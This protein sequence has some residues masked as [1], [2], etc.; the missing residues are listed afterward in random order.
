MLR[1]RNCSRPGDRLRFS[2]SARAG[3]AAALRPVP[4]YTVTGVRPRASLARQQGSCRLPP[5][6]NP[7]P[8]PP[9]VAAPRFSHQDGPPETRNGP[10]S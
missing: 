1:C 3:R 2:V 5:S 4:R 7:A 6:G 9:W 8:L 10:R